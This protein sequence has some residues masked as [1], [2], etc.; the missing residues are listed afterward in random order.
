[1]STSRCVRWILVGIANRSKEMWIAE[2]PI[3]TFVYLWQYAPTW[4][5]FF[6]EVL[7]RRILQNFKA[8]VEGI[9]FD[10]SEDMQRPS[11]QC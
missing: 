6:S 7:G 4:A 10:I 8:G 2:Q 11:L 5:W 9:Q 1:M 3:L